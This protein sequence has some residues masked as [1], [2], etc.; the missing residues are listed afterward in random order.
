MKTISKAAAKFER[1]MHE[2]GQG[3]LRSH[4]KP[5][6]DKRQALAIAYGEARQVNPNYGVRMMKQGGIAGNELQKIYETGTS[7][8]LWDAWSPD[9]RTHFI[10][11]HS[12]EFFQ[13]MDDDFNKSA[14]EFITLTYDKLPSPIRKSLIIHHAMG[15]YKEGGPVE[16]KFKKL[17]HGLGKEF[18]QISTDE[19]KKYKKGTQVYVLDLRDGMDK[20]LMDT[21]DIKAL[22]ES[23]NFAFGVRYYKDGGEVYLDTYRRKYVLIDRRTQDPWAN[24]FF[25]TDLF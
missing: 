19:I 16:N 1:V 24:E 22:S 18:Q 4:D 10:I 21:D 15:I 17:P 3:K 14:K 13:L 9:Q 8:Q 23:G 6:T 20:P 7:K 12:G 5:V 25:D 11:D 2:F